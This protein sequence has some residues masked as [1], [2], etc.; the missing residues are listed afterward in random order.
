MLKDTTAK[1]VIN[2]SYVTQNVIQKGVTEFYWDSI[3]PKALPDKVVFGLV[4]Q[5]AVN[6]D[7]TV[8]PFNFQHFNLEAVTMKINGVDIYG[9]PMKL[10]FGTNRNYSEGF[11][12]LF[13]ICE[14][15]NKDSGLNISRK[16]YGAGYTLIGFTL[17]TGD[18]QEEFLNLVRNGN[19]RLEMRFKSATTETIN[20]VCYYQSQAVLTCDK[21]IDIKIIEP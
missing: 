9:S 19:A 18:F 17:N 10:D 15:W 14:K 5:K 13:E 6:G 12:R 16:D 8:N 3:F 1:Y 20:C 21:A 7:Y 2:R 11:V 4:S